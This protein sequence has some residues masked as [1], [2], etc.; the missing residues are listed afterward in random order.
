MLSTTITTIVTSRSSWLGLVTLVRETVFCPRNH[1]YSKTCDYM[2]KSSI[3]ESGSSVVVLEALPDG[4]LSMNQVEALEDGDAIDL[5]GPLVI[6]THN[7]RSTHLNI[8]IGDTHYFVG[9]NPTNEQWEQIL[10]VIETDDKE[11]ETVLES[12]ISVVDD[13]TGETVLGL[14]PNSN[15][16]TDQI[17]EFVWEYVEYTYPETERLYNVMDDAIDELSTNGG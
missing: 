7:D 17:V 12:A 13:E 14:D 5:V 2:T 8:V 15:P 4:S 1:V 6:D 10:V 3:P 11:D 9:W 16:D